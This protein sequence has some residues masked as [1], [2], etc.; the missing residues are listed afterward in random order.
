MKARIGILA[1]LV[2]L[3]VGV[4]YAQS[5]FTYNQ[6]TYRGGNA[7]VYNVGDEFL[8]RKPSFPGGKEAMEQYLANNIKYP[9]I[10]EENDIQGLV[11][12]SAI[13]ETDGTLSDIKLAKSVDA[14]LDREAMRVVK[15]MSSTKW[16]PGKCYGAPVRVKVF[17]PVTFR[18]R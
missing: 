18:I 6:D 1:L 4:S 13:V 10:A 7:T 8:E 3:S 11:L 14:S 9:V 5:T 2:C 15:S 16:T 12:V 17:I